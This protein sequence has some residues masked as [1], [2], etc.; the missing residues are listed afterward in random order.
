MLHSNHYKPTLQILTC[1]GSST[2][3]PAMN[4][5]ELKEIQKDVMRIRISSCERAGYFAGATISLSLTLLGFLLSKKEF[6]DIIT[7][8]HYQLKLIIMS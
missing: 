7:N 2:N 6:I 8:N 1:Y 4:L 3:R 5:I